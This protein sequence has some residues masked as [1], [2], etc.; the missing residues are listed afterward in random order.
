MPKNVLHSRIFSNITHTHSNR[1]INKRSS[2]RE[3]FIQLVEYVTKQ[4]YL[5]Y[6]FTKTKFYAKNTSFMQQ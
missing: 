4:V 3:A 6:G 5:N 1:I 2:E